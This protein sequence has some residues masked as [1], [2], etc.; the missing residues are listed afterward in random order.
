MTIPW[1]KDIVCDLTQVQVL[2]SHINPFMAFLLGD[3]RLF[4]TWFSGHGVCLSRKVTTSS[5]LSQSPTIDPESIFWKTGRTKRQY[6]F[7]G[8]SSPE[9][10]IWGMVFEE[11]GV[12]LRDFLKRTAR[13]AVAHRRVFGRVSGNPQKEV[14]V[15]FTPKQVCPTRPCVKEKDDPNN[16]SPFKPIPRRV[17][18]TKRRL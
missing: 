12:S 15:S 16:G 5:Y 18:S 2:F 10:H 7:Q 17:P 8:P 11:L 3:K 9:P 14:V 1:K 13:W 6:A 4:W